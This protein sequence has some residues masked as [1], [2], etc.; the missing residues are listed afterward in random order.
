MNLTVIKE[1]RSHEFEKQQG[2]IYGGF[3]GIQRREK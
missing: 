3:V 1:K 2:G